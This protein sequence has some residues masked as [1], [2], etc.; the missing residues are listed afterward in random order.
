MREEEDNYTRTLL[1]DEEENEREREKTITIYSRLVKHS[2]AACG[3]VSR[4][5]LGP[6][7]IGMKERRQTERNLL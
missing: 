7:Q 3:P 2:R 1:V 6:F 5:R 4:P